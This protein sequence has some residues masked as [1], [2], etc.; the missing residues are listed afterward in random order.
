M[1]G[2]IFMSLC[3]VPWRPDGDRPVPSSLEHH[4]WEATCA[5]IIWR[6]CACRDVPKLLPL[7]LTSI[8]SRVC[9]GRRSGG[10]SWVPHKDWML[11]RAGDGCVSGGGGG[12]LPNWWDL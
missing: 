4:I 11:E 10:G 5:P 3:I 2:F 8:S 9:S 1:V 7:Y 12:G 6:C